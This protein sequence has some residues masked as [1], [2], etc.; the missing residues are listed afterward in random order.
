VLTPYNPN[1]PPS[2]NG[3]FIDE[4]VI[5][6]EF[7]RVSQ[8]YESEFNQKV[9]K[10][11]NSI[12]NKNNGLIF[13]QYHKIDAYNNYSYPN[14][15]R[16]LYA[17]WQSQQ[18]LEINLSQRDF[19]MFLQK[20]P[21]QFQYQSQ[22]RII[23]IISNRKSNQYKSQETE[24]LLEKTQIEFFNISKTAETLFDQK[25]AEFIDSITN[26][27][28]GLIFIQ[29][30]KL[31]NQNQSYPTTKRILYVQWESLKY[32]QQ[33]LSQGY[34]KSF[35]QTWR[36]SYQPSAQIISTI[37]NRKQNKNKQNQSTQ[38]QNL[39][40]Q[41]I[42]T[43]YFIVSEQEEDSFDQQVKQFIDE[44]I[45]QN[46]CLISIEY[47]KFTGRWSNRRI[48]AIWESYENLQIDLVQGNF[49][50]FLEKTKTKHK[51]YFSSIATVIYKP[52]QQTN[53]EKNLFI[54]LYKYL[55]NKPITIE[56]VMIF[57]WIIAMI[58]AF[59]VLSIK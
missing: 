38:E 56:V 22:S 48:D 44:I 13:I 12:T 25:V 40:L 31:L 17:K 4:P 51:P 15:N 35:L 49:R 42:Q 24:K 45:K 39:S 18:M 59:V 55:K 33:D 19:K 21:P 52:S 53:R 54:K 28:N 2:G 32:L 16:M 43:E 9:Q 11:I 50:G 57:A 1:N 20:L 58:L 23:S 26:K 34:F 30:H 14:G 29:Y 3:G 27:N 6:I 5:Q 46:N 10:F 7:F 37:T 36:T 8:G 41:V 47:H